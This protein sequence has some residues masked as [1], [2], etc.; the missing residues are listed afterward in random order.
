MF[1]R[2]IAESGVSRGQITSFRSSLSATDAARWIKFCESPAAT[3]P[4]VPDEHGQ[5]T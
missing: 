3:A 2:W 1:S 4:S 5:T